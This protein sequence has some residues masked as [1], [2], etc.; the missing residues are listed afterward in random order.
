M[1]AGA[2]ITSTVAAGRD[3]PRASPRMA[4][5]SRLVALAQDLAEPRQAEHGGGLSRRRLSRLARTCARASLENRACPYPCAGIRASVGLRD[6]WNSCLDVNFVSQKQR[7]SATSRCASASIPVQLC[8]VLYM[9]P[10]TAASAS[11]LPRPTRRLRCLMPPCSWNVASPRERPFWRAP[12]CPGPG[13]NLPEA[14]CPH[15]ARSGSAHAFL[16]R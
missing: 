7:I 3:A 13:D 8:Y 2:G 1:R 15:A 16:P 10:I 6:P 4:V 9:Q 12:L 11:A 14:G 5:L